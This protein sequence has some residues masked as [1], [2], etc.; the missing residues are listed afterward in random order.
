MGLA[1]RWLSVRVRALINRPPHRASRWMARRSH[2]RLAGDSVDST[3]ASLL[4][5]LRGNSVTNPF[6]SI[7]YGSP[8][9]NQQ[10]H[11]VL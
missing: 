4:R 9:H 7:V 10:A 11:N 3:L 2:H 5:S 1:F 8:F 6:Q